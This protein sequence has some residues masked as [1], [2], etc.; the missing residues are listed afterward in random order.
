VV[1]AVLGTGIILT[2][3]I[4]PAWQLLAAAV[5]LLQNSHG[6]LLIAKGYKRCQRIRIAHDGAVSIMTDGRFGSPAMLIAGS[7]VLH[8]IAWLR[9]EAEDG[10]RFAELIRGQ[11]PQ[12]EDWRRLQVIWRHLG[13]SR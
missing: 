6:L 12:D 10:R 8:E 7:V 5:W 11:G 4:K 13:A 2:L 9:F 3:P 1:A